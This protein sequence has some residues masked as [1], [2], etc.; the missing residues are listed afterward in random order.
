MQRKTRLV[1]ANT[2]IIAASLAGG[3]TYTQVKLGW[4]LTA[5]T[6]AP[7]NS[8]SP[9]GTPTGNPTATTPAAPKDMTVRSSAINYQ[10]GTI[11]VEVVRTAGKISAVNMVQAGASGGRNQAFPSLTA[12][13]LQAQGSNFGNIS[14]ATYTTQAFKKAL[15]SAIAKLK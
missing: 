9:T 13:A 10:F 12:A 4:P 1:I 7:S 3:L 6:S 11:Q 8:G 14:N 5:P 15:D 2:A